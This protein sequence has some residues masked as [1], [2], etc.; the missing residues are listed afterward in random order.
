MRY[1]VRAVSPKGAVGLGQ[2]T[3]ETASE[4]GVNATDPAQNL[5]R[6][7]R[8]LREQWDRSGDWP[9]ALADLARLAGVKPETLGGLRSAV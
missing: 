9:L 4:L 3:P 2:L 8:Y 7:A 5:A 6:A 1:C